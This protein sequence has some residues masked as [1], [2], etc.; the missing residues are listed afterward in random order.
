MLP[1][2]LKICGARP[3]VGPS[4]LHRMPVRTRNGMSSAL[5]IEVL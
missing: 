4:E 1:W 2:Q 5:F 3:R